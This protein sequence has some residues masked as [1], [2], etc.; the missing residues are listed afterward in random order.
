MERFVVASTKN[1]VN[2]PYI[3]IDIDLVYAENWE[4]ALKTAIP[5]IDFDKIKEIDR[6]TMEEK[7]GEEQF[8]SIY[9][10]I[11]IVPGLLPRW[12]PTARNHVIRI[13]KIPSGF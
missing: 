10:I 12:N 6:K 1:S 9:D 5:S 4:E 2:K 3:D 7:V 11:F 8:S 13:K